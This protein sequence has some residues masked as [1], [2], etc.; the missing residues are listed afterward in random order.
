V[1]VVGRSN[2]GVHGG[3]I[4]IELATWNCG[5]EEWSKEVMILGQLGVVAGNM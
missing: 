3:Q 5:L 4:K 1:K 2:T